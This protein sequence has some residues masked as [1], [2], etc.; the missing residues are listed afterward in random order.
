MLEIIELAIKKLLR[1]YGYVNSITY[2]A[3]KV[4]FNILSIYIVK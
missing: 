4:K 3:R 1:M 2:S